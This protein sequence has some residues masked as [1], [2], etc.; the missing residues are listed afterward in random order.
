M[1]VFKLIFSAKA[2]CKV[3]ARSMKIGE[4]TVFLVDPYYYT[5]ILNDAGW[6]IGNLAAF[7]NVQK[8]YS[9]TNTF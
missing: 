7:S 8:G 1:N 9:G 3:V 5:T 6:N 4:A 2:C